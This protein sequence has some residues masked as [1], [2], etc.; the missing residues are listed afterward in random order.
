MLYESSC[1]VRHGFCGLKYFLIILVILLSIAL[2][3]LLKLLLILLQ[4]LWSVERMLLLIGSRKMLGIVRFRKLL[5]AFLLL[6][7]VMRWLRKWEIFWEMM[8]KR[9]RISRVE[10]SKMFVTIILPTETYSK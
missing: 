10:K 2:M 7:L 3:E 5:K 8:M 6:Y 4:V 1:K 9:M